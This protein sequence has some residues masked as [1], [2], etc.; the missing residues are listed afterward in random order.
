MSSPLLIAWYK[1]DEC[2]ISL[3]RLFPLNANERLLIPPLVNEPLHKVFIFFIASRKLIP[4]FLCSSIPVATVR[5][6]E[7]K[8]MSSGLKPT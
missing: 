7:S 6:F 3:T 1:K 8:I 4:Y 5:I 2:I